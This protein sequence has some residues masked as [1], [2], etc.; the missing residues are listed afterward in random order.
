MKCMKLTMALFVL[1]MLLFTPSKNFSADDGVLPNTFS[2]GTPAKASEVNENFGFVNHGN[3][4]LID[5]TGKELGTLIDADTSI[6]YLNNNGYFVKLEFL[7]PGNEVSLGIMAENLEYTTYNCSGAAYLSGGSSYIAPIMPGRIFSNG[8]SL[9]YVPKDAALF[10]DAVFNSYRD[11]LNGDCGTF[12]TSSYGFQSLINDPSI[13]G[14][15]SVNKT[16][17]LRIIRRSK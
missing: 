3:L 12:T 5:G 14:E 17:P 7:S 1:S 16:M 11:R 13:T 4:A 8:G 2:A 10:I 9:Y 15:S 6:R